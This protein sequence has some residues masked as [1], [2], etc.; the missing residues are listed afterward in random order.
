[1]IAADPLRIHLLWSEVGKSLLYVQHFDN[2]MAHF[3]AG[4]LGLTL[5]AAVTEI[6]EMLKT[7][8]QKTTG[9]LVAKLIGKMKMTPATHDLLKEH[10]DERNWLAHRLILENDND[11]YGSSEAFDKLIDRVRN[12]G[13]RS[14]HLQGEFGRLY[15]AWA[16][17]HLGLTDAKIEEMTLDMLRKQR[18]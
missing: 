1:M 12:V 7:E 10:R 8:H 3:I 13:E 18:T 2:A 6:A 16:G 17:A 9:Q 14:T 15:V 11:I 5:G 4:P